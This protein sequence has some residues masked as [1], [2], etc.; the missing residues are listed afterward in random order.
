MEEKG[1]WGD[2]VLYFLIGGV[3]GAT[4]A[5]LFAPRTGEETREI[6]ASKVKDSKDALQ[7]KIKQAKDKISETSE[8]LESGATD[9]LS[10]GKEMHNRGKEVIS[11]AIEAGKQAYKE[12]KET[13]AKKS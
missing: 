5:L 3:V 8:R 10:K 9:L 4:V 1:R 11:A 7:D 13:A 12:E 6:I 2:R